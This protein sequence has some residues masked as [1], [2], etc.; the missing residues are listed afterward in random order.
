MVDSGIFDGQR[1]ELIEGDL[2]D[3]MGQ[4]PPHVRGLQLAMGLLISLFGMDRVRGQAPIDAATPDR[5]RNRPEPD[6][7]VLREWRSEFGL[8]QPRGEEI[9][10][11]VE[12]ADTTLYSDMTTKRD[13]YAR[14]GVPEYW[15]VDLNAR[16]LIVYKG[17]AEGTYE[18]ISAF[19]E[20][21]AVSIEGCS[22]GVGTLL[23]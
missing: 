19:G 14:A 7:A 15:V 17:L 20:N 22:V 23:P 6:V 1:F 18:E 16:R 5:E 21:N 8:R 13:L 10:L 3:K 12:V 9:I 2:I 4:K 11:A